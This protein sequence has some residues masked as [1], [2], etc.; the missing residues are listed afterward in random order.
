MYEQEGYNLI[1]AAI[2]V[3]NTIGSGFLEEV[4]LECLEME[5]KQRNIPFLSQ[6]LLSIY[7]KDRKLQKYYKPDLFVYDGIVVEL[8][9]VKGL[10]EIEEAQLLNYLKATNKTVGYLINYG[11]KN[12]L[13]WKRYAN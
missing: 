13:E 1:A 2:E 8:K 3:Y 6:P 7:Y 11:N 10:T 4:Y 12:K 9:A 5:L